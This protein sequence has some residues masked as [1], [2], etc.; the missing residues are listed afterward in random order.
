[1]TAPKKRDAF[2]ITPKKITQQMFEDGDL[3]ESSLFSYALREA[4]FKITDYEGVS[5]GSKVTCWNGHER[6]LE[7]GWLHMSTRKFAVEFKKSMRRAL[8]KSVFDTFE[9]SHTQV[10][11]ALK[12]LKTKYGLSLLVMESSPD[13]ETGGVLLCFENWAELQGL[14]SPEN[15]PQMNRK[16]PT[17]DPDKQDA[18]YYNDNVF[19]MFEM[20]DVPQMSQSCSTN[21]PIL[22]TLEQQKQQKQIIPPSL[23]TETAQNMDSIYESDKEGDSILEYFKSKFPDVWVNREK[24]LDDLFSNQGLIVGK[25]KGI[26]DEI[27][28]DR[29][30]ESQTKSI[31]TIFHL[32]GLRSR[33]IELDRFVGSKLSTVSNDEDLEE[34]VKDISSQIIASPKFGNSKAHC[35]TH[36]DTLSVYGDAI[37]RVRSRIS[38]VVPEPAA[39]EAPEAPEAVEE[40]FPPIVA[41]P[42]KVYSLSANFTED[43]IRT[44]RVNRF[45]GD[46]ITESQFTYFKEFFQT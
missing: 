30:K 24:F 2:V 6:R 46:Y 36:E 25:W 18:T 23:E 5:K 31:T 28:G 4:S 7:P 20:S 41:E 15:D 34:I 13:R 1:M 37:E 32:E 29:F 10:R 44:I 16:C 43:E 39:P 11:R 35:W 9:I 14:K 12:K 40:D 38:N 27:K 21:V 17:D 22:K 42:P 26:I 45:E 3:I 33:K 19:H 8:P